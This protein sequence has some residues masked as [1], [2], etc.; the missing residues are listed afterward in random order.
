MVSNS[1]R[2]KSG[3]ETCG[4]KLRQFAGHI[5]YSAMKGLEC[6]H[7]QCISLIPVME[8][9]SMQSSVVSSSMRHKSGARTSRGKLRQIPGHKALTLRFYQGLPTLLVSCV[10]AL[11][12]RMLSCLACQHSQDVCLVQAGNDDFGRCLAC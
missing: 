3:G 6:E 12:P 5:A 11:M 2:Q 9:L 7:W 4:G 1:M 8:G 10:A